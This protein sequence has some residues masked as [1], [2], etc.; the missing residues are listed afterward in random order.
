M[1]KKPVLL[2]TGLMISISLAGCMAGNVKV[3]QPESQVAAGIVIKIPGICPPLIPCS[4]QTVTFAKLGE[5]DEIISSEI[6]QTS[7]M[8]SNHYYLLNA[9]PGKYVAVAA[10]YSRSAGVGGSMGNVSGIVTRTFGDNILFSSELV[11]KTEVELMPGSLAIMGKFDFGI[12]GRMAI[13]SSASKFLKDADSVQAHYA[14]AIDSEMESRGATSS[15][16][17][18]RGTLKS[19]STDTNAKQKLLES[20]E[21]HIGAGGWSSQL[22][23]SKI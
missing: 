19:V 11:K 9:K 17:F 10:S 16:K 22:T 12:N 5:N 6:Y 14:K 1:N 21:K 23:N 4:N 7:I 20:A 3:S 18:Y 8:R 15:I 2:I 13:V